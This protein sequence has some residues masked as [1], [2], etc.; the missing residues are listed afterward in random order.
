MKVLFLTNIPAPYRV[1]FF[2]E[3]GKN[4]DLTVL[5]ERSNAGD[6]EKKWQENKALNY[7][8]IFMKG[9]NIGNEGALCIEVLKYLNKSYDHI[10]VGGYS[11]PTGILAINFLK[12]NRIPFFLSADGGTIKEE[13]KLMYM[14]K[15]YLISSAKYWLSTSNET[16]KYFLHYGALKDRIYKYPFTSLREEDILTDNVSLE[17]KETIRRRLNIKEEKVIISVGRI[18][19]VKGFDI[20]LDAAKN[21]SSEYGIYII[22]GTPTTTLLEK[23]Q[24]YNLHNVHFKEFMSKKEINEYYKLADLFILATRGDVWGLVINEAMAKGLPVITTDRCVA[25]LELIEDEKNGYIIPSENSELL[26]E[27]IVQ[28]LQNPILKDNMSKNNLKKISNYTIERMA[29]DHINIFNKTI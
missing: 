1:D 6:R 3:L 4:C 2:N 10:I 9:I 28:I 21:I 26:G 15:K 17:E 24:K 23:K 25:G 20:L 22:G 12:L 7:K 8:A 29:I 27:K 5:F 18:I 11:T 14:F 13:N 16:N 19:P